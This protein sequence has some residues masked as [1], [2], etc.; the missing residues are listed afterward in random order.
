MYMNMNSTW[1]HERCGSIQSFL[2][3]FLLV[4]TVSHYRGGDVINEHNIGNTG[5]RD[6]NERKLKQYVVKLMYNVRQ[7]NIVVYSCAQL[8]N[9]HIQEL[10]VNVIRCYMYTN[11]NPYSTKEPVNLCV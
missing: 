10:H 11:S 4:I 8:C 3:I 1:I 5:E 9:N 6:R 7:K 2:F